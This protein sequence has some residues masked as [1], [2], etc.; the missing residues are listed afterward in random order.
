MPKRGAKWQGIKYERKAQEHLQKLYGERYVASPWIRY[1]D[2]V[3][4]K[5][6]WCQ[7]DGIYF[8]VYRGLIVIVEIKLRHTPIAWWQLEKKYRPLVSHLF[9]PDFKVAVVEF[10]KWYD[11]TEPYP[12]PIS[13]RRSLADARPDDFQVT[14]WRPTGRS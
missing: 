3:E 10:V 8:D 12:A 2:L 14:I 6:K 5:L 1:F 7:P 4:E 13:L 11:G 9:G